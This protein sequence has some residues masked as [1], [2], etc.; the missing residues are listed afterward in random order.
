LDELLAAY[1]LNA[2]SDVQPSPYL[3][4]GR[5]RYYF[6]ENRK[7]TW[8]QLS[9]KIGEVL[10]KKGIS[11]PSTVTSFPDAEV[12]SISTWGKGNWW[13]VNRTQKLNELKN[14]NGNHIGQVFWIVLKN[15]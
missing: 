1:G 14:W 2:K 7:H 6:T 5:K 3:T 11:K 8:C 15:K 4:T 13:I 9:E 10:L 12:E